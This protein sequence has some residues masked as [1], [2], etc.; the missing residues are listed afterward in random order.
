MKIAVVDIGSNTI[1]M[2]IYEL[3]DGKL[4]ETH[5]T[6]RHAKLISYIKE[7]NMSAEGIVLL[8]NTILEFKAIA[9]Q[10]AADIFSC[11]ATAS[12][13]RT[14]NIDTITKE[15]HNICG[16][17]VD[18]VSGD[19]EAFYSFSG[20]INTAESFP[21]EALLLDMGG[22][23]TEAVLCKNKKSICSESMSFGSLSLYLE[24]GERGFDIMG[25]TA[26]EY[27]KKTKLYPFT[28][29]N[30]VLVGGTALSI[31]ALYKHF[32]KNSEKYKMEYG[33]L[34]EMYSYLKK[35]DCDVLNIL[36][37][38]TP[39]RVTTVIPGLAAFLGIFDA[40]GIKNISVSTSGIREGY[41]YEKIL[42]Q[43]GD[44]PQ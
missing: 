24:L 15:V 38:I 3:C 28:C 41:V 23:S 32:Y 11:F 33:K 27:L 25:T 35:Y 6:V 14:Q 43:N 26:A 16:E 31:A 1:K 42:K 30:A 19:D 12:L 20:V 18:L 5:S 29:E 37:K 13:R 21:A 22:G 17:T 39:D 40:C 9:T 8:C 4:I 2:K 44:R 7:G 10:E 36:N 34:A